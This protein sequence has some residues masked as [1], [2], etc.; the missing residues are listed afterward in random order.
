MAVRL[1]CALVACGKNRRVWIELASL[2]RFEEI[3]ARL[4]GEGLQG[5]QTTL[6]LEHRP[7]AKANLRQRRR[8]R[9]SVDGNEYAI[10]ILDLGFWLR[11][12]PAPCA[13]ASSVFVEA[14]DD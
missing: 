6:A 12:M 9:L 10:R 5:G 8:Q 7:V 13:T 14:L 2:E 3:V 4:H 11:A 1:E